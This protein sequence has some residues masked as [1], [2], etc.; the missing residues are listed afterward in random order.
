MSGKRFG[1]LFS[2][3]YESS[4]SDRLLFYEKRKND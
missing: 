3:A 4:F 2:E 1:G